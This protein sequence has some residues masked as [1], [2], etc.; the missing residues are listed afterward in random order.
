MTI[1]A[2]LFSRYRGIP[3]LPLKMASLLD[4]IESLSAMDYDILEI[5]KFD[6]SLACN[7]LR[8]ANLPLYG[9]SGKISSMT[10][11]SGLLGPGAIKNIIVSAPIYERYS[12]ENHETDGRVLGSFWRHSAAMAALAGKMAQCLGEPEVD[13]F[14]T[15][16]LV[17]DL[18]KIACA[19][20]AK[21]VLQSFIRS[22]KENGTT[23]WDAESEEF[24]CTLG[25]LGGMIAEAW[26]FP[27]PLVEA[28]RQTGRQALPET[29]SRL[30]LVVELAK[31]AALELGYG[32][33]IELPQGLDKSRILKALEVDPARFEGKIPGFKETADQ[34]VAI[35]MD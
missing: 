11:A 1:N 8:E 25:D 35:A 10:Q 9:Y 33:G 26:N 2:E 32:D 24:G 19:F 3:C 34:A 23:I 27:E 13:D 18:G 22:A 14:F 12:Q 5:I 16:G 31:T 20:E 6:V 21:P 28:V 15:A 29:K 4:D 30:T 7:V 17:H